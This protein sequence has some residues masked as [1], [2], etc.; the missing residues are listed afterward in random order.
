MG[1][2]NGSLLLSK[3]VILYLVLNLELSPIGFLEKTI[4][5]E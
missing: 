5:G 3:D 4:K 1:F 2:L